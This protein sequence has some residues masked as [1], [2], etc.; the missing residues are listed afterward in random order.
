[1]RKII[2]YSA[3]SICF[4]ITLILYLGK[5]NLYNMNASSCGK[6]TSCNPVYDLSVSGIPIRKTICK[7]LV[8][9]TQQEDNEIDF[10]DFD[11]DFD[12][13]TA[14]I[15]QI[16]CF[17]IPKTL[18]N[19][20]IKICCSGNLATCFAANLALY[21]NFN[22]YRGY[23]LPFTSPL[24]R[25]LP[26]CFIENDSSPYLLFPIP[27]FSIN[28][29]KDDS[30]YLINPGFEHDHLKKPIAAAF[31]AL[32][33]MPMSK[34]QS[35]LYVLKLPAKS[36]IAYFSLAPYLFQTGRP[37]LVDNFPTD[38]PFASLTDTF[39]FK[40]LEM[41]NNPN[42]N[43]WL[44]GKTESLTLCVIFTH[45]KDIAKKIHNSLKN[46]IS[47]ITDTFPDIIKNFPGL[48]DIIDLPITC[49]PIPGENS[50]YGNTFDPLDR[51]MLKQTRANKNYNKDSRLFDWQSE[52]TG[53]VGRIASLDPDD[54]DGNFINWIDA[55]ADQS[56]CLV[57][58]LDDKE[59]IS[60]SYNPNLFELSD[61]N[62]RF[63]EDGDWIKPVTSNI[64]TIT[65][66]GYKKQEDYKN[67]LLDIGKN[68][69]KGGIDIR[70][71]EVTDEMKQLGYNEFT[72]INIESNPSPFVYY[73][74]YVK[75]INGNEIDYRWSQTGIDLL[76]Y[77]VT[78]YGDCRDTIY[79]SSH[80]FCIGQFDVAVIISN[81]YC[82]GN[83]DIGYNNINV[84]ESAN[85]TSMA[86]FRG[87]QVDDLYYSLAV[88]RSDL[89]CMFDDASVINNF[90]FLPTGSH[91]NLAVSPTTTL[92]TQCRTYYHNSSGTSPRL[93]PEQSRYIV[94]IFK[95][96]KKEKLWP[97]IC[98]D[99]EAERCD[100]NTDDVSCP[101]D[102]LVKSIK[103]SDTSDK[104]SAAL[105]SNLRYD[106]TN[107]KTL[108][109][110]V[111]Y[112]L[113]GVLISTLI[114]MI[115][116]VVQYK[117][118]INQLYNNYNH[119]IIP[120]IC[121]IAGIVITYNKLSYVTDSTAYD[122]KQSKIQ[123]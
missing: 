96:C 123:S 38:L 51:N 58:G 48:T 55:F 118:P 2:I 92:F 29:Y 70:L 9:C 89:T 59:A 33:A 34:S 105:C 112:L 28:V 73:N 99:Y 4:V 75:D 93:T 40:N 41:M 22:I 6:K 87:D 82:Y 44:D 81:N 24:C 62:G 30:D 109:V 100:E 76:Q 68:G 116:Q 77:N 63:S 7:N 39:N 45:N 56:N 104:I 117:I 19:E 119:F 90:Q 16:G 120:Y 36:V 35:C 26:S 121:L 20:E 27:D 31:G 5:Y 103:A 13:L 37:N 46:G 102:L 110:G 23:C 52:T 71:D 78:T 11:F 108:I 69:K 72:D 60:E 106:K 3:I 83:E 8:S 47:V 49:I 98:H 66:S 84:Y 97:A 88:S 91:T 1:M 57:I 32:G 95:P 18:N 65:K 79:P 42:V 85:Q 17:T 12:G 80:T 25:F 14:R 54:K 43:D 61:Q 10:G 21:K 50:T 94:R 67:D 74:E 15:P 64:V 111:L 115:I 122:I 114:I 53:L 107:N 113:V 101:N 86:S